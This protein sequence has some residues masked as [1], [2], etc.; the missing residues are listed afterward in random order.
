MKA[1]VISI[2]SNK[3]GVGKTFVAV[4][5]AAVLALINPTTKLA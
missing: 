1:K 2:F 5:L 3:G 4:N